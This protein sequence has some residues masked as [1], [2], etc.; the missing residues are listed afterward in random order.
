VAAVT[1]PKR[2]FLLYLIKPS[3]YDDDGYVVQWMRSSI[4]SNSLAMVYA[5]AAESAERQALGPDVEIDI[6]AMDETN[7]RV[8]VERIIR[9][10]RDNAGF[11]MVSF[12]A[13]WTSRGR[14]GRRASR[15]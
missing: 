15:W 1:S 11:G 7:V 2:R 3:H 10:I 13:R 4:P 14:C 9:A 5:L 6:T 8:P 12:R